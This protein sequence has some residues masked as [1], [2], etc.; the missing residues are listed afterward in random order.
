MHQKHVDPPSRNTDVVNVTFPEYAIGKEVIDVKPI[1]SPQLE[2]A[3]REPTEIQSS[4]FSNNATAQATATAQPQA[5][6]RYPTQQCKAP[7]CLGFDT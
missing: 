2:S 3:M 4:K 7:Q 6:T 5:Q 1:T